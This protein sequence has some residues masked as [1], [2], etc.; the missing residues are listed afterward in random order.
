LRRLV[1]IPLALLLLVLALAWTGGAP[2]AEAQV[3]PTNTP[4]GPAHGM[5]FAKGCDSPRNVGQSYDCFYVLTNSLDQ[6]GDTV[7]VTALSDVI[8]TANGNVLSPGAALPPPHVGGN[9]LPALTIQLYLNGAQCYAGPGQTNPVPVGGSGANLCVTPPT[10]FVQF[11]RNSFY[12]IQEAD[13]TLPGFLLDDQATITFQDLC[14]SGANNCPVGDNFVTAG[15]SAHVNTPT[16][17]PTN[18]PTPT[19]TPTPTPTDTPTPTPTDT[20]TPTPTDTPTNT[21]TD[22]PTPTPTDTP[23]STPTQTSTNPPTPTDTPTPT[24]TSTNTPTPTN[25]PT[26]TNTPT[27]T[28]TPTPAGQG[29]TPGFWKNHPEAWNVPTTTTLAAAGFVVPASLGFPANTTL[30]QALSFQGGSD[31]HGAAEILLR[32]AAAGYLNAVEG[33]GY[34]LSSAQVVAEVNTALASGDRATILAEATRLDQFNNLRC[35]DAKTL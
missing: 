11:A 8:H 34:P 30:Q 7:T 20:P 32:A 10:G 15:S 9:L 29:C 2:G 3:P 18:T 16:P 1:V 31:L 21:P 23:T 13:L 4:V 14:N 6:A 22:T 19:D 27:N 24:K 26:Q 12:T 25:T 17:T 33:L 28:P 35:P 5:G